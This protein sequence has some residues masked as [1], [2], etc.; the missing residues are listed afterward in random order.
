MI[1]MVA[2]IF[3]AHELGPQETLQGHREAINSVKSML[4]F[5]SCYTNRSWLTRI[6]RYT[7]MMNR[8]E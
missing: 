4:N 2:L 5:N 7:E 3:V 1:R 8:D 6:N